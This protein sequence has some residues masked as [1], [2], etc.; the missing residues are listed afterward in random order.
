[1][2]IY[3]RIEFQYVINC[4][5]PFVRMST[6]YL[7]LLLPAVAAAPPASS[8]AISSVALVVTCVVGLVV[9]FAA[10]KKLSRPQ[11]E[12]SEPSAPCVLQRDDVQERRA[13]IRESRLP[14]DAVVS[15]KTPMKGVETGLVRGY[16]E[17]S[18][19][20]E[21]ELSGSGTAR[22]Q[23]SELQF[24]QVSGLYVYPIKSGAGI[25]L[26]EAQIT[27]KGLLHDREWVVIDGERNKFVT[28]RRYPK[29]ALLHPKLLAST[30]AV[31]VTSL[32]LRAE[33]M[34][35][36]EV[37]VVQTGEGQLRLVSI[38]KDTVEAVDQGDAAARWLDEFMGEENR[39]FRLVR[40]RDGFTRHTKPK[41]APGHSTNFADAFPFLLA[42]EESLEEFNTTLKTPVP[43]NRFR[44][45][46]VQCTVC[47]VSC[48][49]H[50]LTCRS[51]LLALRPA[52]CC[53]VVQRSRTSTGTAS[54]LAAYTSGTCGLARA[55]GCPVW[56]RQLA[57][58][59]PS[60]SHLV[61][62]FASA[63]AT[64]SASWTARASRATSAPTWSWRRRTGARRP[65]AWKSERM[66]RC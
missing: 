48:S 9:A 36:L 28:Q 8:V 23:A 41:Y 54:P 50:Q 34:P 3:L 60:E 59:T 1:V 33:G 30:G 31:K 2:S 32:V 25:A 27:P 38:W 7:I 65:R 17:K 49:F 63:T 44:P 26:Q 20:Y 13:W 18:K 22:L 53:G 62:S 55:A 40:A 11:A 52:S 57:R 29:M 5:V 37:P 10:R 66:S 46:C 21:V 15:L 35:D 39:S 58:F 19:S 16:D 64:F 14:V 43:M 42:L 12:A 4:M 56:T 47:Y 51:S 24:P 61:P 6:L 45:K